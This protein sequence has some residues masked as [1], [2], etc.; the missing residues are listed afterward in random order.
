MSTQLCARRWMPRTPSAAADPALA[1]AGFLELISEK[2]KRGT[3]ERY[4]KT[5]ANRFEVDPDLFATS[6]DAADHYGRQRALN[7]RAHT[8]V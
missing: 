6:S 7:F 8:R 4:Y 1:E 3:V 5:S 2:Q